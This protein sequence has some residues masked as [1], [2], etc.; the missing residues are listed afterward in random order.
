MSASSVIGRP[1]RRRVSARVAP[2]RVHQSERRRRVGL[3]EILGAVAVVIIC[4]ALISLMWINALRAIRDQAD[5]TRSRAEAAVT[6]QANTLADQV[7]LELQ[8]IDQSLTV[9]QAAWTINPDTFSLASWRKTM[10]ALTA[11]TN[12]LFVADDKHVIVQ[13]INPAAVGQGVGAAYA[14]LANGSLEAIQ[15]KLAPEHD[16]AA[17]VGELGSGG[18]VRQYLMYLVRPLAKPKG[19][20]IGAAYRSSALTTVFAQA[21]LGEGGLGALV[22]MQH[23]GVQAVAGTAALQP[24]LV[25]AGTPMFAEMLKRPDGGI[26]IG[27]TAIDDVPRIIAFRRVP[28]RDLLVLVGVE[29]DQAMAPAEGWASGVRALTAV[30]TLLVLGIGAA[31]LWEMWH[32]RSVRRRQRALRQAEAMLEAAQADLAAARSRAAVGAA[33]VQAVLAGVL[34]GVAVFDAGQHLTAWNPRFAA[35][36]DPGDDPLREGLAFGEMLRSLMRTGRFGAPSDIEADGTR[37]AALLRP[38]SGLGEVAVT[39][40]GGAPLVLRAQATPDGGL[41][42]ILRAAEAVP[43]AGANATADAMAS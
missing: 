37:I 31:V 19:W 33:Q 22:D 2:H 15:A 18:V 35:L 7:Q 6:V 21:G 41:V 9:L 40:P 11:V 29:R 13:D 36:S 34:A 17:L 8:V 32:W 27:S 10:P 42:L 28:G 3:P 25:L 5:D 12:D 43:T 20:L 16:E 38:E 26:W 14:T 1:S 4:A 24:R 30:A 39:A 23:G